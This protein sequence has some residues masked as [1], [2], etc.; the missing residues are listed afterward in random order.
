MKKN[1]L[2][3]LSSLCALA[4]SAAVEVAG[5]VSGTPANLNDEKYRNQDVILLPSEGKPS[6][7]SNFSGDTAGTTTGTTLKSMTAKP[8]DEGPSE[9]VFVRNITLDANGS[10]SEYILDMGTKKTT[11]WLPTSGW[12]TIDNT[13]TITAPVKVRFGDFIF[14]NGAS[15]Y[16]NFYTDAEVSGTSMSLGLGNGYEGKLTMRIGNS[17]LGKNANV[18][19]NVGTTS[20]QKQAS[21]NIQRGS[22]LTIAQGATFTFTDSS[23]FDVLGTLKYENTSAFFEIASNMTIANTGNV[24]LS[25]ALSIA[26][27]GTVTIEAR[28]DGSAAISRASTGNGRVILNG[29]TLKIASKNALAINTIGLYAGS[30][31][32]LELSARNE[33]NSVYF[34]PNTK[35]TLVLTGAD[36]SAL[37]KSFGGTVDLTIEGFANEKVFFDDNG[38]WDSAKITATDGSKTYTKEQLELVATT[39]EMASQ[40]KYVLS[41]ITVPEPAE[42]AAVLGAIAIAFALKRKAAA[43][44]ARRGR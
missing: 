10:E 16:F 41:L 3:A 12:F 26:K 4:A 38:W 44:T 18:V 9:W 5:G 42:Y 25:N 33:I 34:N 24:I 11:Y 39:G 19:F 2:F 37:F 21:L 27:G 23:T 6:A 43:L 29:G 28:S 1:L 22:S 36:A 15:S 14:Q 40:G 30:S 7:S 35:L 8:S 32:T 31:S 13:G 20:F 17:A